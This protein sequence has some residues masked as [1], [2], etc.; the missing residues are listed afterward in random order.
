MEDI[1]E[2]P[3]KKLY[4]FPMLIDV[5]LT[6]QEGNIYL[7]SETAAINVT[8][9]QNLN[10]NLA[11][12]SISGAVNFDYYQT[13]RFTVSFFNADGEARENVS[14]EGYDTISNPMY[15]NGGGATT[16]ISTNGN[17]NLRI[18]S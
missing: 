6:A 3:N 10:A 17:I 12:T 16:K 14:V 4:C 9:N 11:V 8:G 15:I 1:S 18:A 2:G 5:S 7:V 13:S